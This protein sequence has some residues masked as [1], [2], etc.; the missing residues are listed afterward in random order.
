MIL[1][2]IFSNS[3]LAAEGLVHLESKFSVKETAN[4]FEKI[5]RA[6]GLTIFARIN[7]SMNA[8]SVNMK[9]RPTEVI[10]F[11]NPKV[12]TPLMQCAGTVAIDLP[13][14]VLFREDEQGKVW[15]S[16]NDPQYLKKRHGIRNCDPVINKISGV[17]GKLGKAATSK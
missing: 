12:G 2:I 14:K 7:H 13:Q 3:A 1:L 8:S 17:L 10:V 9:L 16:Y 6:K 4:K 15:L 11:G 5:L